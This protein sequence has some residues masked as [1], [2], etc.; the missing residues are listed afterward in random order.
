M[1]KIADVCGINGEAFDTF[2]NIYELYEREI[3]SDNPHNIYL[4]DDIILNEQVKE[5]L[6]SLG[7]TKV[8]DIHDLNNDI[9]V[10][11]PK[12]IKK[13]DL[14]YLDSKKIEY[15]LNCPKFLELKDILINSN[16][17]VIFVGQDQDLITN[18]NSYINYTGLIINDE[19]DLPKLDS[20]EYLVV[21]LNKNI[22]NTNLVESLEEIYASINFD[23]YLFSDYEESVLNSTLELAES[24]DYIFIVDSTRNDNTLTDALEGK[25]C[26]KF[27]SLNAFSKF[28]LKDDLNNVNIGITGG[29]NEPFKEIYNYKC[30]LEFLLFYKK[31]YAELK[32]SQD[33]VNEKLLKEDDNALVQNLVTNFND[34]NKDG[35]YIRG[36]LIALGEHLANNKQNRYLDLAYAYETFQTSVL[37]H[38]DIIDNARIRRGKETIPR[39]VCREYLTRQNNPEYHTDTLKLANSL[40]ICAG[41]LGFYEAN[42]MIVKN[43]YDLP[44]FAEILNFYNDI[45][46]KTIKGEILDVYLPFLGKYHYQKINEEDILDIY[47][48]KT[49]WYTIIGPFM[50]G[51][52]LGGKKINKELEEVLNNIGISFQI[53]DDIL[54]IFSESQKIGKSNTSDISEFKQTILYSHIINT[55]YKEEFLKIYG[56]GSIT[57]SELNKVR[58]LLKESGSLE[59][60]KEYLAKLS[61]DAYLKIDKL[62]I[63]DIGK[64]YLKGLLIYLNIREK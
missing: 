33:A 44:N 50:L 2:K 51:Y 54:G 24:S 58:E 36:V 62:K 17:K 34:L 53:K 32:S 35:K 64:E 56:K 28:V 16:K 27:A 18:L 11:G 42:A 3:N 31:H 10:I 15:Y 29:V 30:L 9:L 63:S 19:S 47:H 48:L 52:L 1:I 60:A 57:K 38:D 59:Y 20:P 5:E 23:Y 13:E 26:Y 22:H 61:S 55:P 46:I 14:E 8:N 49:S 45:I 12:G 43:Y 39:R 6:N 37:I 40:G 7:I 25:K 21:I 4:Y 41:D